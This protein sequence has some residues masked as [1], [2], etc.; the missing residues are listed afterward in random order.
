VRDDPEVLLGE[1][2]HLGVPNVRTGGYDWT[3]YRIFKSYWRALGAS[4]SI[5][6][7]IPNFRSERS[8]REPRKRRT[9]F[10]ISFLG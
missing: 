9:G 1:Q 2:Q 3:D 4:V 10:S 7:P 5:P 6:H 8:P